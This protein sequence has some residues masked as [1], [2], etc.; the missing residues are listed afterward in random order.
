MRFLARFLAFRRGPVPRA[1]LLAALAL[2]A[3]GGPGRAGIL[4]PDSGNTEVANSAGP[5][6]A[7][8]TT[9]TIN[10]AVYKNSGLGG[11]DAFAT[12]FAGLDGSGVTAFNAKSTT[13]GPAAH[14]GFDAHAQYLY[15]YQISN[16]GPGRITFDASLPVNAHNVT[17]YGVLF[18][19]KAPLGLKDNRGL[20]SGQTLS[21]RGANNFGPETFALGPQQQQLL[22]RM[23]GN[24]P[25]GG[26]IGHLVGFT[27]N[28]APTVLGSSA[29]LAVDQPGISDNPQA[30]GRITLDLGATDLKVLFPRGNLKSGY[31]SELIY[32]TSNAPPGFATGSLFGDDGPGPAFGQL[33]APSVNPVPA[34]PSVV[35]SALG[36]TLF[37][38]IHLLRRRAAAAPAA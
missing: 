9:G 36:I 25:L 17:S 11:S 24:A 7:R 27:Q 33:A 35:L 31:T 30:Y 18:D 34:P 12:G 32:V 38:G 28:A 37:A 16:N 5:L 1:A 6:G 19:G 20:V 23:G 3:A 2:L 14:A 8:S 15:L 22:D 10:F 21:Y 13:L 29:N 26:S 4:G